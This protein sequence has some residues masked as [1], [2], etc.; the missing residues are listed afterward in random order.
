MIINVD[1]QS[2]KDL[3]DEIIKVIPEHEY[4]AVVEDNQAFRSMNN[5]GYKPDSQGY[6]KTR[7]FKASLGIPPTFWAILNRII[8][9]FFT[10]KDPGVRQAR[11]GFIRRHYPQFVKGD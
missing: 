8:P 2:L 11:L 4:R 9:N 7:E 3:F 6:S 1:E 5:T 10:H